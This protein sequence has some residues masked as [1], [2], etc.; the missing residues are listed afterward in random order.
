MLKDLQIHGF[1]PQ[2]CDCVRGIIQID[3]HPESILADDLMIDLNPCL[4]AFM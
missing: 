3:M 2:V 4:D 1:G